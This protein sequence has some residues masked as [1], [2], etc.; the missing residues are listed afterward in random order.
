MKDRILETAKR[1][2]RLQLVIYGVGDFVRVKI[3]KPKKMRPNWTYKGG[4]LYEMSNENEI[5]SGVYM[6]SKVFRGGG[7]LHKAPTY[8][9]IA[10]WSKESTPDLYQDEAG[11]TL[12][13]GQDRLRGAD[14][15]V[16]VPGLGQVRWPKGSFARK[17]TKD[18]ILRVPKDEKDRPIAQKKSQLKLSSFEDEDDE[19]EEE[20]EETKP[21]K[22]KTPKKSPV[23]RRAPGTR[24]RKQT[25]RLDPSQISEKKRFKEYELD[26]IVADRIRKGKQEFKV[27]W[28]GYKDE[29]DTWE[30]YQNIK[31]TAGYKTYQKMKK[32]VGRG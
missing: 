7:K 11:G 16:N 8:Q 10:R 27:R 2:H 22:A 6:V 26:K 30:P 19:Q 12:P 24:Q 20:E 31:N 23:K 25:Q 13:S 3:F 28:K 1:G 32:S 17:F 15:D 21:Q 9:I 5:Y 29:D 14:R 4:P 18:E